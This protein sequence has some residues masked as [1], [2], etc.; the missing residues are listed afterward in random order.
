M[1]DAGAGV[2]GFIP[3]LTMCTPYGFCVSIVSPPLHFPSLV[4]LISSSPFCLI[5]FPMNYGAAKCIEISGDS[6]SFYYAYDF[7]YK[8]KS[9][10]KYSKF[11]FE[12]YSL[13]KF[14][15]I[16]ILS[17]EIMEMYFHG[18]R[19]SWAISHYFITSEINCRQFWEMTITKK[20]YPVAWLKSLA[21]EIFKYSRKLRL[22][23]V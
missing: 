10:F 9:I 12:Q 15:K 20:W 3:S 17:R 23:Y 19:P 21:R 8:N 13:K 18:N 5:C 7:P 11:N 14:L 2:Q 1:Q 16:L 4:F 6:L 22:K